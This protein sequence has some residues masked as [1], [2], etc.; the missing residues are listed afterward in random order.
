VIAADT[1]SLVS[2]FEGERAPDTDLIEA[3][4]TD[5]RLHISPVVLAELLSDPKSRGSLLPIVTAWPLLEPTQGYWIRASQTRAK[6]LARG[7]KA[8]LPDTLIAQ[9]SIDYNVQLITRDPDFEPFAKHCGLK[10]G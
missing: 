9:A 1:S 3:A 7:L 5:G 2:Y 4:L 8:K 10:L 6:V